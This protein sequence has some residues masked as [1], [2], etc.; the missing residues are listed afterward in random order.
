MATAKN[1]RFDFKGRDGNYAPL[2]MEQF[3]SFLLEKKL[4]Y[5]LS[6][7]QF[8]NIEE[9]GVKNSKRIVD[10]YTP[11]EKKLHANEIENN[12]VPYIKPGTT[13]YLPN[14]S[15]TAEMQK[16]L[17]SDIFLEQTEFNAFWTEVQQAL[18]K[19]SG[20]VPF[21][22]IAESTYLSVKGNT[23]IIGALSAQ[24]KALNIRIWVYVRALGKMF[25][26]SPWVVNCST[27]KD[28]SA[29]SFSIEVSYTSTLQVD[30]YGNEFVNQESLMNQERK[31]N[32]D[33]FSKF[34]QNNDL[35]F[36]RFEQL[37]MERY[38]DMALAPTNNKTYEVP[39][40]DL[41]T[42]NTVTDEKTGETKDIPLI[43]DMLGLVD[44]VR[45]DYSSNINNY[46]IQIEGRDYTKLFVEDG[47]YF[48]PLKFV[49]GSPDQWFYG[50]DPESAWFKRN[51]ITGAYDYYF[52]YSFQRIAN[53][54]WF[55]INQ[56]SSIGIV[57][58]SLFASC[59]KITEKLPVETG[60]DKYKQKDNKVKGIWQMVRVFVDEALEDRRIVDRSLVNPEGT[61]L[62]FFNKVCQEPFVEFWGDTYMNEFDLIVRQPPFTGKAVKDVINSESYITIA[63][64]DL[65]SLSLQYDD[66]VYAWYRIMPQNAMMGNSQFSSLAFVP[67]IFFNEYCELYG[68]K[69]C[70]TNDIYI[71][72]KSFM[73]R[74]GSQN[75]NTLSQ[76]L[77][78]DL[79]FVIETSAYLPFTRKGTIT[80]NGDRR[81]KVGTFIFLEA[82]NELFYVTAVT[83]T[84]T[85]GNEAVDRTTIVT[86]E[87]GMLV[88]LIDGE[89]SYF[90]IV[91][92]EGLK[93]E[94]AERGHSNNTG[95]QVRSLT[96]SE[97]NT[98]TSFK[99]GNGL[100]TS[101]FRYFV[102]RQKFQEDAKFED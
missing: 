60:D 22:A 83:N 67:I 30:S 6:T 16:I 45:V 39:V 49:E 28:K 38:A 63:S 97:N 94:I 33:W 91:N 35:I 1:T 64:Q 73:G 58:D 90:N 82:T 96:S 79:L 102:N 71:S 99:N 85:F 66:R 8:L 55:V 75:L 51:M 36:I 9:G 12:E 76:A 44:S 25:D 81:I 61:L 43:W 46:S 59:A 54:I 88:D 87:R 78:N 5:D 57:D 93:K 20:Y 37:K 89:N 69:R 24:V 13:V 86:V 4:I 40:S 72:E 62:D 27:S 26:I 65:L 19:D 42:V 53:V 31:L 74:N 56:L 32:Q 50:G 15:I 68:N 77:V 3:M 18:L 17:G 29:G 21:D 2:M 95:V 47:S 100:N 98:V 70:I 41:G 101:V 34:V 11:K 14:D 52:A 80:I 84:A 10:L 23:G 92:L 48:I 7:E